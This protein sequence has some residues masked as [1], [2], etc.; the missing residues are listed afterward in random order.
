MT[1]KPR[2]TLTCSLPAS[3]MTLRASR[4]LLI[5]DSTRARRCLASSRSIWQVANFLAESP[6]L[7][8]HSSRAFLV[9]SRSSPS[10][11]SEA[12]LAASA[13]AAS[14]AQARL[15]ASRSAEHFLA[16]VPISP[17]NEAISVSWRL[18]LMQPVARKASDALAARMRRDIRTPERKL[19][20]G[21]NLREHSATRRPVR[22]QC[23]M[24]R[25]SLSRRPE[26]S[27]LVESRLVDRALLR[28]LQDDWPREPGEL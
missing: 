13:V 14:S 27:R 1:R 2:W 12:L 10:F 16:A 24:T 8:V 17:R 23:T 25:P 6:P 9:T 20:A 19:N 22:R 18:V 3:D 28:L 15:V 26:E 11:C 5:E 21:A 4:T 7:L